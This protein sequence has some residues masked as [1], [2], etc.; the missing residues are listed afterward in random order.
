MDSIYKKRK[1][2]GNEEI[3][4]YIQIPQ[5][6]TEID[7]IEWW[8]THEST[9]PCLSKFTF[10]ILCITATSDQIFS[11]AGIIINKRRDRLSD[12]SI[13]SVMCLNSFYNNLDRIISFVLHL[14]LD[15]DFDLL[16]RLGLKLTFILILFI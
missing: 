6:N 1:L 2:N 9:L 11:K 13:R 14:A 5:E 8:K 15:F 4:K 16:F 7:P 3:D 10:D 12:S